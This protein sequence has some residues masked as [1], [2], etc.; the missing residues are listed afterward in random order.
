MNYLKD[1]IPKL[2]ATSKSVTLEELQELQKSARITQARAERA[3][4]KCDWSTPS[5]E[6]LEALE[7]AA[8]VAFKDYNNAYHSQN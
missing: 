2:P 7:Y 4:A 1:T 5:I 3:E 6:A 8:S